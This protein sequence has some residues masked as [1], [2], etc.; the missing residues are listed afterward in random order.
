MDKIIEDGSIKE[1]G[2]RPLRRSIQKNIEDL[3][4]EEVLK[5]PNL[6]GIVNID[7]K[8]DEFVVKKK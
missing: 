3:L 8:K 4:S 7:Y 5:N 1:Y 6:T 2:A